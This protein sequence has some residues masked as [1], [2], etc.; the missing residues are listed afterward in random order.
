MTLRIPAPPRVSRI[1][2]ETWTGAAWNLLV[3]KTAAPKAG[4][5]EVMNARSAFF[6]LVGFTPTWVPETRKPTGYVPEL[7]TNFSLDPGIDESIGAE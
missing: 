3:V 2:L 7:G 4:T 6:V 5:S 1:C